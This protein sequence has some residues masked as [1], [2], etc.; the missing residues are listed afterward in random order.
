MF[1]VSAIVAI[2]L[3]ATSSVLA[4]D[5]APCVLSCTATLAPEY[6]CALLVLPPSPQVIP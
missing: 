3:A 5:L 6:G 4:Q 2:A 1:R